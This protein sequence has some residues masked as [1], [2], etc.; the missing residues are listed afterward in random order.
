MIAKFVINELGACCGLK[1]AFPTFRR[2]FEA[3]QEVVIAIQRETLTDKLSDDNTVCHF[4]PFSTVNSKPFWDRIVT[5]WV[6]IV[7]VTVKRLLH[8]NL[9]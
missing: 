2:L 5:C 1:L 7:A 3:F 8:D 4:L 6:T 9:V